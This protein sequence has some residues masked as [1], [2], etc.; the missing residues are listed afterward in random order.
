MQMTKRFFMIKYFENNA[1]QCI[2]S[3]NSVRMEICS[4]ICTDVTKE[5]LYQYI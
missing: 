5:L 4:I 2:G 1:R 3:L